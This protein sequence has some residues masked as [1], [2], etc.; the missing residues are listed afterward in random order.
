M[1]N[2]ADLLYDYSKN[3]RELD[4]KFI[5]QVVRVMIREKHLSEYI[6]G[7][8]FDSLS[9][10]KMNNGKTTTPMAYH[11]Y[12]R[13]ILV[14]INNIGF[15]FKKLESLICSG[16]FERALSVNAILTQMLLHEIDHAN[17]FRKSTINSDDFENLLLGVCCHVDNEFLRE[18]KIS[19]L[20]MLK[21]GIYLN[22]QLFRS[23]GLQQQL[24]TRFDT[25]APMERMANIN[26]TNEV[27][28]MLGLINQSD[29]IESVISFLDSY[30]VGYQLSG[31]SS[32]NGIIVSPTREYLEEV[33]RLN[34]Y[35]MNAHFN[36]SFDISMKDAQNS[37]LETRL[38]LGLD[39]SE[40]EYQKK[41]MELSRKL[42]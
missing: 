3:G 25:S 4:K 32:N 10:N 38:L 39:I 19:Q 26:S 18:S 40:P 9:K 17:Q 7:V 1:E 13:E 31:Y 41:R 36:E 37:S 11:P 23:L 33:K 8:C 2:I 24:K 14:D 21:R 12:T 42:R 6:K 16:D 29:N 22:S 5:D 20:M 34:I 15:F 27:C 30:L 35:G 28:D